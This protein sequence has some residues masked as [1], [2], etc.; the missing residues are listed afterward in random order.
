MDLLPVPEFESFRLLC[1]QIA[2]K[3]HPQLVKSRPVWIFG[4]GQF[5]QDVYSTLNG[6]GFHV[7][8]FIESRPVH[9]M[10]LNVPVLSW[11][12][13]TPEH[14]T[15]QIIIGIFNRS[16]PVDEL[17]GIAISAGFAEVFMPWDVYSQFNKQLGWR[18]WLSAPDLILENLVEIKKAY[19]CLSDDSS[20]KC[21]LEILTFRLG[22]HSQYS[23]F[24]HPDRQ[25]F[26][27]LTLG[28][29]G[30]REIT[31]LDGGAYNGDTFMELSTTVKV[32]NAFLFEPDPDNFRELTVALQK[33]RLPAVC[34][35]LAISDQYHIFSFNAGNGEAGSISASGT[36]HIAAVALDD[37]L[38]GHKVDFI[39]LDIEGEEIA[40]LCGAKKLIR[41]SRPI[42][43]I[44]LY[45]RPEDV[46]KIPCLV[47]D[48]CNDYD[49]FIR[50]HYFNSF[51]SVLYAIP[52]Q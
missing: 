1:M 50:Q 29:I 4:A 26:N 21:F 23:S 3:Q 48:I 20:R 45:H 52:R 32:S 31:F 27:D 16:M 36:T 10:V 8:G 15:E 17:Q 42:L 6:A 40:A 35:P 44:S 39:K 33:S 25:Y 37:M 28:A 51:D 5:G 14:L 12:Q 22:Q 47:V 34:L 7:H 38:T 46:W 41:Q 49:I 19:D 9:Q 18:Y 30:E 11:E 43:A 2:T 13:L 24:V